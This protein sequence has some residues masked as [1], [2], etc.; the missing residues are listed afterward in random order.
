MIFADLSPGDTKHMRPSRGHQIPGASL[1]PCFQ[2]LR[3]MKGITKPASG[4]P[5]FS[6]GL[7]RFEAVCTVSG[8]KGGRPQERA[9]FFLRK[10][11]QI[12]LNEE[13]CST[14]SYP[15]LLKLSQFLGFV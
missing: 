13:D 15:A 7:S 6:G 4:A 14:C 9:L 12:K 11:Q 1:P 3:D 10:A 5:S 2:L 8:S